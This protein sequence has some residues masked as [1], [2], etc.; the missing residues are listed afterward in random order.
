MMEIFYG[1]MQQLGL[2]NSTCAPKD[3]IY[4]FTQEKTW[5]GHFGFLGKLDD[6]FPDLQLATQ[7]SPRSAG[8]IVVFAHICPTNLI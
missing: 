5:I 6:A 2:D 3:Q 4:L 7:V 1:V 8:V